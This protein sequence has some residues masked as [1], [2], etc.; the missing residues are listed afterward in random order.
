MVYIMN[1]IMYSYRLLPY[2]LP[3]LAL[4]MIIVNITTVIMVFLLIEGVGMRWENTRCKKKTEDR[5]GDLGMNSIQ[6]QVFKKPP[7]NTHNRKNT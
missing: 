6:E 1:I 5:N 4:E 3:M 7:D 2:L